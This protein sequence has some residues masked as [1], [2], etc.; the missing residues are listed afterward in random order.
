MADDPRADQNSIT[1]LQGGLHILAGGNFS[2]RTTFLKRIS[3]VEPPSNNLARSAVYLG[4]EPETALSG[5][6]LSVA[7]EIRLHRINGPVQL[8]SQIWQPM[9]LEPLYSRVPHTLSGGE[10]AKLVLLCALMLQPK[11]LCMDG[12][13]EQVDSVT[14]RSLMEALAVLTDKRICVADNRI[15][16]LGLLADLEPLRGPD[17]PVADCLEPVL[18]TTA[19]VAPVRIDLRSI[20]YRYK[21]DLPL[22]LKNVSVALDP[23]KVYY[24]EGPNGAGKSTLAKV[25]CG[26]VR[27]QRGSLAAN[28]KTYRPWSDGNDLVSYHFQN[29]D[30]GRLR[31]TLRAELT[32]SVRFL[33]PADHNGDPE[34]CLEIAAAL[35]L[36]R[37]LD[38]PVDLLPYTVRKRVALAAALAPRVPWLFMDEPTLGQDDLAVAAI[39][40]ILAAEAASGRG[41]IV[42]SHADALRSRLP[43]RRLV[44][45]EGQIDMPAGLG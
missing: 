45:R 4:P 12:M 28:H 19:D 1:E 35:G 5:L 42:V 37:L 6:T 17:E 22:I 23:G 32:A 39:A 15:N 11:T 20:A 31:A 8:S 7:Q 2:G 30:R 14:R 16:E 27:P 9:A 36:T 18:Y 40:Q 10:T 25:L 21:T 26:V 13:L 33:T 29:P 38:H 41:V 44:L 43:G 24:L 34:R 3:G